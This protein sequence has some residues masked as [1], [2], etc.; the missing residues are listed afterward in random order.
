MTRWDSSRVQTHVK[1]LNAE[2]G[3]GRKKRLIRGVW[4]K[5]WPSHSLGLSAN[6]DLSWRSQELKI[7]PTIRT[8]DPLSQTQQNAEKVVADLG[9]QIPRILFRL[10]GAWRKA[11]GAVDEVR[12]HVQ[13][14]IHSSSK[15]TLRC[16]LCARCCPRHWG[17]DREYRSGTCPHGADVLVRRDR[18]QRNRWRGVSDLACY[19]ED[20]GYGTEWQVWGRVGMAKGTGGDLGIGLHD[21]KQPQ[22]WEG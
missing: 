15:C 6:P 12:L 7:F 4:F 11:T 9:T 3:T 17:E 1:R 5:P 21:E 13:D 18:Q 19:E 20:M 14:C 22:P 2:V 10:L 16:L 8:P